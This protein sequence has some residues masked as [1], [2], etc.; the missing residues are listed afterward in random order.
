MG[1]VFLFK[2]QSEKNYNTKSRI[3]EKLRMDKFDP[4]N[5]LRF[6]IAENTLGKVK[7]QQTGKKY[8][9]LI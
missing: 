7:S 5:I 4:I 1:G 3:K 6:C 2:P 9:Q 8:L